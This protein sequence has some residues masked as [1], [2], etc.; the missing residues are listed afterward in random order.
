VIPYPAIDPEI[1]RIGPIA[2]RWYGLMYLI[3]FASSYILVIRRIKDRRIPLERAFIDSLYTSLIIGLLIGA[4]LGYVLFYD[5]SAYLRHPVDI[6]AVWQGGMSFHGGLIGCLIAGVWTCK[7]SN[8][9]PWMV[10]DL[11]TA[12]APIGIGLGRLG[13]FINGEL[14]G[15]ITDMPWGMVFPNGG[16]L[17]RHPSQIYEFFLE[18]VVLF[19][20]LWTRKSRGR[21][22]GT[23]TALF[24]LL[25]GF[26]R[27]IVEFFRE[28]D[29]QLGFV[30]GFFTMGQVLS[31][32]MVLAGA[33]L[34]LAREKK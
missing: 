33:V 12:T 21:R 16:P 23:L 5:L 2:V 22:S 34:L 14:Y 7:R 18:G 26:S 13:N 15:R 6:F 3:G 25:Y 8:A 24:I 4:R 27:F 1:V 32:C 28:P 30:I 10:S 31:F 11:I 19:L 17:P 29:V 9:D 20:I